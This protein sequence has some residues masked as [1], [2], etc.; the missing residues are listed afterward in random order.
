MGINMI[1]IIGT[2]HILEKSVFEV[3]R[4]IKEEKPDIIALEL[5]VKRFRALEE[6]GW[7]VDFPEE[8]VSLRSLLREG[9]RGGS[10]PVLLEGLLALIQ[11]DLGR[12]FGV[13][14]GSDMVAAIQ[15]ARDMGVKIALIDRDI[16]ITLNHVLSVPIKE[17]IKLL[18]RSGR[19]LE[20]VGD[21]LG[22]N[23]DG[24]LREDNIERIM[25]ELQ[26]T[27]PTLYSALVD[28]RDRYMAYMLLRLQEQNPGK[29]IVAIFG[30]GH[31]RGV[32][33]YLGKTDFADM[34]KIVDLRPVSSMQ[35]I[36]LI[37]V[38]FL[39]YVFMKIESIRIRR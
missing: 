28:E 3:E 38:V 36:P 16:E 10:L 27:L 21:L 13:H 7:R 14:P 37:S 2:G 11:R 15:S 30:A 22:T 12:R 17:K 29:K 24:L 23:I 4:F 33:S 31:V 25:T 39:T 8:D 19:D 34:E 5:D 1:K 26:K 6:R 9:G 32:T 35:L 20:L 18:T